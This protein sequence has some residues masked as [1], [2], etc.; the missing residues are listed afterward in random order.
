MSDFFT[1]KED[2]RNWLD[3]K[4][5]RYSKINNNLTVD[6]GDNV[7]LANLKDINEHLPVQ[8]GTIEGDF[9]CCG[10][11]LKSLKGSP[12]VVHGVFDCSHN[13]L[14][15]LKYSPKIVDSM[16]S[17]SSNQITSMEDLI[18]DRVECFDIEDNNLISFKGPISKIKS[19]LVIT[20]NKIPLS[21][22][23]N[24]NIE[25]IK[26]RIYSDFGNNEEFYEKVRMMKIKKEKELLQENLTVN[27]DICTHK[28][29]L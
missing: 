13:L 15:N 5:V 8:F 23:L 19:E 4:G 3:A 11:Q 2:I 17:C 14:K 16:F 28:K 24:F 18:I 1:N 12:Q 21:E 22:L 27:K 7:Y 10:S 6:V 26:I 25:D 9:L 20:N 29:R